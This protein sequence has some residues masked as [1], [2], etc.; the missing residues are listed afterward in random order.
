MKS[1]KF[2][3][4]AIIAILAIGV[5]FAAQAGLFEAKK[6][7]PAD[8]YQP[9]SLTNFIDVRT[10]CAT[11]EANIVPGVNCSVA[12]VGDHIWTL[13]TSQIDPELLCPGGTKFCCLRVEEDL[14]PCQNQPE[15]GPAGQEIPLKVAAVYCKIN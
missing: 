2:S 7:L 1:L 5:T 4:A 9:T 14:N 8:C 15:F 10:V 11:D 12:V 6:A 3:F 13:S